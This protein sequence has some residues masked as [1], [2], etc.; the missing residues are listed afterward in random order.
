MLV[1][2]CKNCNTELASSPKTQVCGCPNNTTL[3]DDK[4]SAVDLS[5]VLII[6]NNKLDER[7]DV[8]TAADLMYQ[9]QRR[10]RKV[11]RLDFEVR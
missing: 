8:L 2:R 3:T 4:I 11:T 1:I 6:S 9:E 5:K 7:H 10:R